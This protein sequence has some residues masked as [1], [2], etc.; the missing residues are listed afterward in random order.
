MMR[1]MIDLP[2]SIE[3]VSDVGLG[4]SKPHRQQ[5]GALDL[6]QKSDVNASNQNQLAS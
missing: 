3:K 2:C 6:E 5:F 4:F 1:M